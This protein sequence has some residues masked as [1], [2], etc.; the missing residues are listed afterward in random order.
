MDNPI[1]V[2]PLQFRDYLRRHPGLAEKYAEI[3]Q[4]LAKR[5]GQDMDAYVNGKTTFI[6]QVMLE[7]EKERK[8]LGAA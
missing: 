6:E 4:E 7:I 2:R 5:C 3:K 1:L 8:K